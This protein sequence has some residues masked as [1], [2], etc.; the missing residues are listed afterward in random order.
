MPNIIQVA[1][2]EL[3]VH[4]HG[5]VLTANLTVPVN[6]SLPFQFWPPPFNAIGDLSFTLPP[7]ALEFRGIDDAFKDEIPLLKLLPSPPLSGYTITMATV[8]KPAWVRLG[9]SQWTGG[10]GNFAFDGTLFT[11]FTR[12]WVPPPAP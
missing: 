8:S 9:M 12:T 4:R 10:F 1:D 11:R 7:T 6:I 5:D 3:E 2:K